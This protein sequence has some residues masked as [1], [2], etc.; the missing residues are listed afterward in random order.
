MDVCWVFYWFVDVYLGFVDVVFCWL[1]VCE[2]MFV[3]LALAVGL[4]V[5][6]LLRPGVVWQD[7]IG[8]S[9]GLGGCVFFCSYFFLG[10]FVSWYCLCWME[11][12]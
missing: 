2:F 11:C 4:L 3:I 1:A 12:F 8:L 9:V 5:W 6:G 7:F 10:V